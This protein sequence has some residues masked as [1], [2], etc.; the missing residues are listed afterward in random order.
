MLTSRKI[1]QTNQ[2][3]L[4]F[5]NVQIVEVQTHIHLG[6]YMTKKCGWQAHFEYIESKAWSRINLLR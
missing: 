1:L 2:P 3:I 4:Y 5:N 6:I